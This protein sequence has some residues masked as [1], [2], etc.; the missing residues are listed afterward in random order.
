MEE[1]INA[2]QRITATPEF[3]QLER[4]RADARHNE[5]AAINHARQQEREKWQTEKEQLH[6]Q[7]AELQSQLEKR[8]K[9]L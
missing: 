3:Q 4:M 1:A 9:H 8:A 5:A 7:I 2:Y 6:L